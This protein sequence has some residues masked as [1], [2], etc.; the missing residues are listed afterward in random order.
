MKKILLI[1]IS[2]FSINAFAQPVIQNGDNIPAPGLSVPVQFA[3]TTVVGNPGTNQTWDFSLLSFTSMGTVDVIVPSSSPIGGSF[4]GSNYALSLVGQN[5]YSFFQVSSDKME[6]L[7]WTISSPGSGNDYSPNPRT[8][9]KFPF[10]YLDT[11]NDTW[12]KVGGSV[13]NVTVT[14]DGYGTLV[15]PSITY[16]DVVRVKEDYGGGAIDYQW[17]ILNPLMAVAIFDHNFNRLYHFGATQPTGIANHNNLQMQAGI[18]PNPAA[19]FVTVTN[20]PNGSTIKITDIT[21][22]T[23]YS[24][25]INNEKTTIGTTDFVNGVYIIQVTNNGAITTRKLIVNK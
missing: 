17:Y 20:I 7:A 15:T 13:N 21:G 19:D 4:P 2:A 14:Y 23:V 11:E 5:S 3:T 18:Y 12:Q 8:L 10:N 6:V 24:S 1:A 9:M 16:N 22:K 25:V